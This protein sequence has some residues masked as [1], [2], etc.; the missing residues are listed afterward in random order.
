MVDA[1]FADHDGAAFTEGAQRTTVSGTSTIVASPSSGKRLVRSILIRPSLAANVTLVC[2]GNTLMAKAVAASATVDLLLDDSLVNVQGA[3]VIGMT[4]AMVGNTAAGNIAATNVQT[5]INELDAE[6]GGLYTANTWTAAQAFNAGLTTTDFAASGSTPGTPSAGQVLIGGGVVKAGA[7]VSC[8]SLTATTSISTGQR[9]ALVASNF[10]YS[11]GYKAVILGSVGVSNLSDACTISLGLDPTTIAG[12]S[13][14]GDGSEILLRRN[15][16]L[17]Q[18]NIGGTDW[19]FA[20][21]TLG[22]VS[23]TTLTASGDLIGLDDLVLPKTSG[24]GIKVDTATPTFPWFDLEGVM[25]FDPAGANS[26]DY[27]TYQT[28]ISQMRFV[29]NDQ[30]TIVFHMPHDWA[31]G[32]DVQ[33]HVHW[34]HN[35][36]AV[37]GNAVFTIGAT[38]AKGHNQA[39]FPAT[40]TQTITYATTDITTTPQRRHRIDEIQLSDAT[41]SGNYLNRGDFEPDG[42]ILIN[43][44]LTTLPTITGGD[45]FVHHCD[46]HYQSTGIGTKQKAPNFYT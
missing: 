44:Q 23:C 10:G 13:F 8:T 38:Y 29:A 15:M 1:T 4:A 46:L 31:P 30:V 3:N 43:V 25:L 22:S 11:V 40:K 12:P 14:S 39:N 41:G 18:P 34:S 20:G 24:I 2:G 36:T 9:T 26:P 37:S 21:L 5:A 6:K 19:E 17:I 7:G 32:T 16:R 42:L 33:A 35:G 28:G 27:T 45:L